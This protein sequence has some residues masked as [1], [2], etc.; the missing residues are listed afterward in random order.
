MNQASSSTPT[1]HELGSLPLQ[2]S[3]RQLERPTAWRRGAQALAG[4]ASST[5]PQGVRQTPA[6]QSKHT[7]PSRV[8]KHRAHTHTAHTEHTHTA[9]T[10]STHTQHTH[11]HTQHT[12]STHTHTAHTHSTHTAQTHTTLTSCMSKCSMSGSTSQ[13]RTGSMVGLS[14]CF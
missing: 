9:H 7:G 3:T 14:G 13:H 8:H 4:D 5:P 1:I 2:A 6:Q 10:H 11:T 12:H